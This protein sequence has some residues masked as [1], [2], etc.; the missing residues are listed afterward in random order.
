MIL[1]HIKV[2]KAL[3]WNGAPQK[4]GHISSSLIMFATGLHE[5]HGETES[6]HSE[7][8]LDINIVATLKHLFELNVEH[9]DL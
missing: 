9:F 1:T 8:C 6:T 3:V 5:L 7:T 4:M 2:C